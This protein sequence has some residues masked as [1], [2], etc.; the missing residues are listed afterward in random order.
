MRG[1]GISW[2]QY[3]QLED[4]DGSIGFFSSFHEG[5]GVTSGEIGMSSGLLILDLLESIMTFL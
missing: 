2:P 4:I 1:I 5:E 3:L